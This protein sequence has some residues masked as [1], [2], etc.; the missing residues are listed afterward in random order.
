M[1]SRNYF[2]N[3][4]MSPLNRTPK[5]FLF[6]KEIFNE[7]IKHVIFKG[8]IDNCSQK[9]ACTKKSNKSD[10]K[11]KHMAKTNTNK[12]VDRKVFKRTAATTKKCNITPKVMRGGIRL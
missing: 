1:L 6:V 9:T 10:R 8:D 7:Q 2:L 11:E 4:G 5:S 12:R 3:V